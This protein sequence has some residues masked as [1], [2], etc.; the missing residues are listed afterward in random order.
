MDGWLQAIACIGDEVFII[1][2]SIWAIHKKELTLREVL[3]LAAT[4]YY[5]LLLGYCARAVLVG[6]CARAVNQTNHLVNKS[7][8][9]DC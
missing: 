9:F 6:Y 2:A 1:A 5:W 4:G 8:V 3:L 7:S